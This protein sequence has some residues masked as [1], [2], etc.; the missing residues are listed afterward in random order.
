M[1]SLHVGNIRLCLQESDRGR[2]RERKERR[3]RKHG[4]MEGNE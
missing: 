1:V 2:E 4:R 3:K